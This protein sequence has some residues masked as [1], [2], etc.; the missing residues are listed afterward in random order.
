MAGSRSV[1]GSTPDGVTAIAVC[2]PRAAPVRF[3]GD[4][5]E[6][7]GAVLRVPCSRSFRGL[8]P[9]LTR[10][11]Q[12]SLSIVLLAPDSVLASFS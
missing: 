10:V 8:A 11:R 5:E 3:L 7:D 9:G 2:P 6:S 4:N 12:A 1:G